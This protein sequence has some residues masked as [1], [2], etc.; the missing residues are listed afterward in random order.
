M[1]SGVFSNILIRYLDI[2]VVNEQTDRQTVIDINK[3]AHERRRQI[4]V[5][6]L[7]STWT[8]DGNMNKTEEEERE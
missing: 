1:F 3:E 7:S 6:L 2:F 5:F 8:S 4:I